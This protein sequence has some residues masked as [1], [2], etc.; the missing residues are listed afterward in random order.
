V[1]AAVLAMTAHLEGAAADLGVITVDV[2]EAPGFD[3]RVWALTRAIPAGE[4]RTYG[5]LARDLGDIALS[6]DVGQ[7]LGRNPVPLIIPCHR[8]VARDGSLGGFSA[9]GGTDT[10]RRLL[11]IERAPAVAQGSLFD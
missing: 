4:T 2:G 9:P 8:V 5:D 1:A 3:Q 10:K 6:R 11:A 7:A